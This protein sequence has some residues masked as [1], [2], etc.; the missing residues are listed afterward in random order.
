MERRCE[1]FSPV[2]HFVEFSD[3]VVLLGL[4][5]S[6]G[7]RVQGFLNEVAQAHLLKKS[8]FLKGSQKA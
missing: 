7:G 6:G 4:L 5:G 8:F 3:G 2:A 1:R